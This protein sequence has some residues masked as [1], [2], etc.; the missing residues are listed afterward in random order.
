MNENPTIAEPLATGPEPVDARPAAAVP[1]PYYAHPAPPRPPL[2]RSR[3]DRV[4]AGVCGGF[5]QQYGIDPVLLRILLV[6][7]AVFTGGAFVIVYVVAW[8]LIPEEPYWAPVAMSGVA[9]SAGPGAASSPASFAAG[10]TGTFVDPATGRVYGP[11]ATAPLP[12]PRTEPRSHL[13]LITVS[14]SVAVG[15][16][17]SLLAVSGLSIPAAAV[18]GAMLAVLGI[19]LVVG[20]F[21]GRARWLIAPAILMLLVTQLAAVIPQAVNGTASSGVGDRRWTPTTSAPAP[22]E[23]GAG[24]ARL[25]LGSLP[26]G[27]A[28]INAHVGLGQLL[29][30][31]PARTRVL[32]DA[33]VGAGDL[34]LPG[35]ADQSGTTQ[36]VQTTIEPGTGSDPV[37][38]VTLTAEIGVGQL[39]VRHASS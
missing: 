32:L 4:F 19:G 28:T 13:G 12:L 33:R 38:T 5:G 2:R 36:H 10:G 21:R 37:T 24:D 23:L 16:L 14:A 29:V 9:A 11:P 27:P 30:I 26:P 15:G 1:P 34:V 22:F 6:V 17:L 7:L 31:V 39:E 20:A 8:I 35:V 3:S 18:C 25:D